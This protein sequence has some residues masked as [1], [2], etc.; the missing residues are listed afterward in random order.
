MSTAS[1]KQ[2]E[3][4]RAQ[5]MHHGGATSL[6]ATDPPPSLRHGGNDWRETDA[7]LS[8]SSLFEVRA[9]SPGELGM[10]KIH[11]EPNRGTED[12]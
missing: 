10:H 2:W 3:M 6:C 8:T 12:I 7:P 11:L 5:W 4:Q 9:L 1:Q